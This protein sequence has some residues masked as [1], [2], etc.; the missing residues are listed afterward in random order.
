MLHLNELPLRH[1]FKHL[2]GATTGPNTYKGPIGSAIVNDLRFLPVISFKKVSGRVLK[3]PAHVISGFTGD[4]KYL[5]ELCRA[6]QK[7]IVSP[8]LETRSPGKIC[9]SRWLTKANRI[10]RLYVATAHIAQGCPKDLEWIFRYSKMEILRTSIDNP[11]RI[12]D[13]LHVHPPEIFWFI[14][15]P[16]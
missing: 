10:L 8:S 3:L 5:Y 12:K 15:M 9:E 2:D 16:P 13:I 11:N 6:V 4:Q 14:L 1:L 7:G